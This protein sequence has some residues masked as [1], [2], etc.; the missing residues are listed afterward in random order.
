MA[1]IQI[2]NVPDE[3]QRTYKARAAAAGVSLQEYL[4][5]EL[6]EGARLRSPAQIA[7]EVDAE[8]ADEGADG[9][10]Q[11]SATAFVRADRDSR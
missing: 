10:S 5:A 6:V 2:R 3:V 7:A 1:T 9:F 4:L 8:I 11:V